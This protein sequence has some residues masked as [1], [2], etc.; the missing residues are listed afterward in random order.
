MKKLNIL[1][2]FALL[3][4]FSS[5]QK[6][7]GEGPLVTETRTTGSFASIE[8]SVSGDI[9]YVQGSDYKVELTAQ[10]NILNVMETPIV[11]N[12]LVIRFKNNVRVKSHEQITIKVTAPSITGI[13][14][15]GS[16][17]V[18]VSSPL[19]SNNLFFR[20]SGS[21]NITL[22]VITCSHLETSLSGSGNISIAGGTATTEVFK[23]SGSGNIDAPGVSSKSAISSTSGSG[24]I[25]LN[26]SETLDVTIT[27]SG[28]V[29]YS[30]NPV[31]TTNITGSG[32]VIHQ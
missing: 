22:P 31:V 17:N 26:A 24:T 18:T 30:G 7:I 15:T 8:S 16:G 9:Y 23:I 6:I 20:L 32:R 13:G 10:Q 21:G 11:N 19:N 3:I 2:F 29:Y 4:S 14:A 28:S 1:A 5:C 25:R 27:G 12:E